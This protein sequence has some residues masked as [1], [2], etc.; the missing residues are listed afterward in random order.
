MIKVR[1]R[2]GVAAAA[3]IASIVACG[4]DSQ[5]SQAPATSPL[6]TCGSGPDFSSSQLSRP[7]AALSDDAKGQA[8]ARFNVSA[9][10]AIARISN[11]P[12]TEV[13][14]SGDVALFLAESDALEVPF[15]M[16]TLR[17]DLNGWRPDSWGGCLPTFRNAE[18]Q[19][20]G[21]Q[22]ASKPGA[23]DRSADVLIT[24][25]VCSAFD[26]F[27]LLAPSVRYSA[28]RIEL[29]VW[30]PRMQAPTQVGNAGAGCVAS[31]PQ[32]YRISLSEPVG[33][34]RLF[35]GGVVPAQP[36]TVGVMIADPGD[37]SAGPD[38]RLLTPS[39]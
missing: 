18:R 33:S 35:D 20:I 23:R 2:L 14:D 15:A 28:E 19:A 22:L 21:W 1:L 30:V 5:Q 4:S 32:R 29:T 24:F 11:L 38:Y 12:W 10:A 7:P 37:A 26:T 27:E 9:E 17:H 6:L 13:A 16:V 34:R 3:T 36:A 8:L 31:L 25:G 39:P